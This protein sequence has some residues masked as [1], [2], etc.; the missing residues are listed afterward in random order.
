MEKGFCS[1]YTQGMEYES[2]IKNEVVPV[3]KQAGRVQDQQERR[4]P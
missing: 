3:M 2:L 4:T 1:P